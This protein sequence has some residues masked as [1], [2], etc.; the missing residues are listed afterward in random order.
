MA[1]RKERPLRHGWGGDQKRRK[2]EIRRKR[3]DERERK[4]HPYREQKWDGDK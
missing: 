2:Q 3:E 1:R 4:N